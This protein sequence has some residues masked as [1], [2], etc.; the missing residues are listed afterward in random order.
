MK[1]Q[2]SQTLEIDVD[3]AIRY[4]ATDIDVNP[5]E[6]YLFTAKGKWRD[7][8]QK[9]GSDGWR[10]WWTAYILRFSRLPDYDLFVL[11]GN[12]GKNEKTNFPIG[13]SATKT[14]DA[15]GKLFLF[16]NDLWW[17]YGNNHRIPEQPLLVEIKRIA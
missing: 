12:I 15:E 5:G 16:A 17:F 14:I 13:L 3:P 11:G 10:N 6:Q 9:C 1:L 7:A 4:Q 2:I 8:S